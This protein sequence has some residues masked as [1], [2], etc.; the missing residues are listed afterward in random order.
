MDRVCL[1]PEQ[2]KPSDNP[3]F[4]LYKLD[5]TVYKRVGG[6]QEGKTEFEIYYVWLFFLH[7]QFWPYKKGCDH[8][9]PLIC[10]HIDRHR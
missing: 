4:F 7:A 9:Q 8:A 1:C 5:P 2:C 10:E 3:Q 6:P